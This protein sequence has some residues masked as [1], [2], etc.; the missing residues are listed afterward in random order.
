MSD[1]LNFRDKKLPELKDICRSDPQK[2]RG[3]SSLKK[4][5]LINFMYQRNSTS[6]RPRYKCSPIYEL[7]SMSH[8]FE[9]SEECEERILSYYEPKPEDSIIQ[10]LVSSLRREYPRCT[11]TFDENKDEYGD[12]IYKGN[13]GKYL[14]KYGDL[15]EHGEKILYHGTDKKNLLSIL[16]DDFRLTSNPVHGHVYGKGIYFT[17]DIDKAIYYSERGKSTKYI[18]VC[19]VH[20]GDI[21]LGNARMDVH[22]EMEPGLGDKTYDTSVDN[23]YSP[24]Q[25]IK[26]K[27]GTYNILGILKIEN[28]NNSQNKQNNQYTGSFK[29]IN[30]LSSDIT[31][32]WVPDYIT[33][34]LPNVNIRLCRRMSKIPGSYHSNPGA[35]NQLCQIGHT[36]ICVLGN[37]I[38]RIIKSKKRGEIITI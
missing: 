15:G 30:S 16:N 4:D 10:D 20:V 1:T 2:Y 26:K 33:Y 14:K 7:S 27:N 13:K 38:I 21:C 25:F 36:F 17:N 9:T 22:P 18:I 32:Y 8:I 34:T 6:A 12:M 23:I 37:D 24:K 35:T 19:N 3:F 31:L 28:Y 29:I 11:I 5:D